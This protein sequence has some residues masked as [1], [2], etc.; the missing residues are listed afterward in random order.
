[1]SSITDHLL[2]SFKSYNFK[3]GYFISKKVHNIDCPQGHLEDMHLLLVAGGPVGC[4]SA[5]NRQLLF[6]IF[7]MTV[8]PTT[9]KN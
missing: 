1:M 6:N 8:R 9:T 2:C 3:L 7:P 5:T 4:F